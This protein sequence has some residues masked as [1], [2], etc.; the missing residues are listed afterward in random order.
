MPLMIN[1]K[2]AMNESTM[3]PLTWTTTH[4]CKH[5]MMATGS[6]FLIMGVYACLHLTSEEYPVCASLT[7]PLP[8]GCQS[9]PK[10]ARH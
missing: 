10:M 8:T 5:V 2:S 9:R 7:T 3:P 4:E 1:V 6:T